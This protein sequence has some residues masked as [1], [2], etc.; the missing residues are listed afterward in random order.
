MNPA[1]TPV[2][3]V[4][5]AASA[6]WV[7]VLGLAGTLWK[8]RW[9]LR[10]GRDAGYDQG[11][12]EKR[13]ALYDELF[14]LAVFRA[15]A[16]SRACEGNPADGRDAAAQVQPSSGSPAR[17]DLAGLEARFREY[18]SHNVWHALMLLN[19]I[20]ERAVSAAEKFLADA[21]VKGDGRARAEV[22]VAA[23][24]VIGSWRAKITEARLILENMMRDELE[25]GLPPRRGWV[26]RHLRPQR[27]EWP[28]PASAD[29]FPPLRV[30]LH[31]QSRR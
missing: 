17:F 18:A 30:R 12:W 22:A 26:A 8:T 9:S 2:P 27:C 11:L 21:A 5:A 28:C 13:S 10:A 19:T 29:P 14:T 23:Q 6:G 24:E 1:V 20:E 3:V 16:W 25:H 4:I 31:R 7:A 15:S